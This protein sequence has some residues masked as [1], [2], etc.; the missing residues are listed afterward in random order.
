MENSTDGYTEVSHYC[1]ESLSQTP[2]SDLHLAPV[3]NSRH[4]LYTSYITHLT[5]GYGKNIK[6]EQYITIFIIY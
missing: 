5:D 2:L 3:Q 6:S 4:R 1:T